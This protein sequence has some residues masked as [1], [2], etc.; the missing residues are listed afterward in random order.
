MIAEVTVHIA[1]DSGVVNVAYTVHHPVNAF[2][3]VAEALRHNG[4]NPDG[5][6]LIIDEH[7]PPR[8]ID[9]SDRFEVCEWSLETPDRS[10]VIAAGRVTVSRT[11]LS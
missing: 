8:R 1:S 10:K 4:T 3:L 11:V 6:A 9:A 7:Q 5:N 2:D